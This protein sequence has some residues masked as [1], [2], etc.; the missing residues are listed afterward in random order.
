MP[1]LTIFEYHNKIDAFSKEILSFP[2]KILLNNISRHLGD[3]G[4]IWPKNPEL[5]RR[6]GIAKSSIKV[7]LSQL[8]K[9]GFI[10][11]AKEAG[12]R[13]IFLCHPDLKKRL[14]VIVKNGRRL[15][16]IN[17][18]EKRLMSI[19]QKVNDHSPPYI[20][21]KEKKK[22]KEKLGASPDFSKNNH[23]DLEEVMQK[24]PQPLK[25]KFSRIF[26]NKCLIEKNGDRPYFYWLFE[27]CPDKPSPE[28][29]LAKGMINYYAEYLRQNDGH[30]NNS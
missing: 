18:K 1:D 4:K 9:S 25:P 14:T 7:L 20:K 16:T 2:Q 5:A 23:P 15:M 12:K 11:V 13:M 3:N 24:I 27:K 17:Q 21:E 22:S 19:N 8:K 28:N 30:Q 26:V 29:W 10:E 6:T